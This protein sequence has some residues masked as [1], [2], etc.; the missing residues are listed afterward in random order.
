MPRRKKLPKNVRR[1]SSGRFRAEIKVE[2]VKRVGPLRDTP[3]DAADDIAGLRKAHEIAPHQAWTLRDGLDRVYEDLRLTGARTATVDYYRNHARILFRNFN[4]ASPVQSVTEQNAR[5]YVTRRLADGISLETIWGKELQVLDRI[6]NLAVARGVLI[7]NPLRRIRRPR[8]RHKRRDPMSV[9]ALSTLL[10]KVRGWPRAHTADRDAD[11]LAIALLTGLRPAEMARLRPGDVDLD[12]RQLFVDGKNN[13][14]YLPITGE[15]EAALRRMLL[16][17]GDRDLLIGSGDLIEKVFARWKER[18]GD[19]RIVPRSFRAGFATDKANSGMPPYE[20]MSLMG[21][22]NL[23]QTMRYY[24]GQT[25]QSREAMRQ[26]G[27]RLAGRRRAETP[28]DEN[29]DAESP[30]TR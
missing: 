11:V 8:L 16:R 5:E 24:H 7:V 20:L 19:H 17:V 12:A 4:E 25:E 6:L 29:P 18:L 27:E 13:S 3:E 26:A 10:D 9:E 2:G 14:R 30:A 22:T 28:P 1:H 15:L 21:H 23:R